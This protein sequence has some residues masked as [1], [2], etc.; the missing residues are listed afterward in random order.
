LDTLIGSPTL[1]ETV[2]FLHGIDR[3]TLL[4]GMVGLLAWSALQR[5]KL[6]RVRIGR[7]G[8]ILLLGLALRLPGMLDGMWYDETFSAALAQL[9]IGRLGGVVMAD[10]HPPIYYSLL[11]YVTEILGTSEAAYRV[12]ALLAGLASIWMMY[13][14]TR[15][16]L[17][18]RT[19]ALIAALIV[20]V[21]PAHIRYSTEARAY[22]LMLLMVQVAI[23]GY[24]TK[25]RLLFASG[26]MMIP[27]LHNLGWFYSAALVAPALA[28]RR[29]R[30]AAVL[31]VVPGAVWLP[32][33]LQ[34]SADVANGF[35]LSQLTIAGIVKPLATMTVGTYGLGALALGVPTGFILTSLGISKA[36]RVLQR[37]DLIVLLM[38]TI[39]VPAL[40]AGTSVLWHPVYLDRAM[41]PSAMLLVPLWALA[42]RR[43][44]GTRL[45]ALVGIGVAL[46]GFATY[47]D[48]RDV[49][50]DWI[51][52]CEASNLYTTSVSTA[53]IALY[54]HPGDVYL[55]YGAD[56]L[57]QQL[58]HD[59]QR[60]LGI[61]VAAGPPPG[62]VCIPLA[63]TAYTT[64][65]ANANE[66]ARFLFMPHT[67]TV[68]AADDLGTLV[69]YEVFR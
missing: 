39:G 34:Q 30:L 25:R 22:M 55:W 31:A 27:L 28:S 40:A 13:K 57:S 8:W 58:P 42:I 33:A 60:T 11:H 4:A 65:Q 23:Y 37:G 6:I 56:D 32:F 18:D 54:Y 67:S 52:G 26:L 9:D 35:W 61:N 41:L 66:I 63:L 24:L 59:V 46:V 36:R 21:L 38:T 43:V 2:K 29:L 62:R 50:Q 53:I 19:S 51:G 10:V 3:A 5:V 7:L 45:L 47:G 64:T 44:P 68:V 20:A 48:N 69:R 1:D 14:I 16:L 15:H 12:P 17:H 49:V